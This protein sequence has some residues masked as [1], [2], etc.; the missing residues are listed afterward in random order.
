M[1]VP[2]TRFEASEMGASDFGKNAYYEFTAR[3]W[4]VAREIMS[5][6]QYA[7][8]LD[9]DVAV[10]KDPLKYIDIDQ[11]DFRYQLEGLGTSRGSPG[12]IPEDCSATDVNGGV[13]FFRKSAATERLLDEMVALHDNITAP[14]A[15]LD[16]TFVRGA[17]ERAG[18]TLCNFPQ[19]CVL[20]RCTVG[21]WQ[22]PLIQREP[23]GSICTYHTTCGGPL[24]WKLERL[25]ALVYALAKPNGKATRIEEVMDNAI[26]SP[27][28]P[29]LAGS[30]L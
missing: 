26:K 30:I 4:A 22:F 16:Q 3:K 12:G 18:A 20:G 13:L 24:Q 9:A 21:W 27:P 23:I 15:P 11:Y 1:G 10:V 14:G 8:V 28:A 7:L 5:I 2:H 29:P 6:T 19:P 17:A 25:E